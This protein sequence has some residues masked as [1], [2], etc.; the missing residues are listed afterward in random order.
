MNFRLIAHGFAG[1]GGISRL[2]ARDSTEAHES[3]GDDK[4]FAHF[5]FLFC[6]VF[7]AFHQCCAA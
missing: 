3:D 1:L 6:L 5:H 2:H 4:S 7:V